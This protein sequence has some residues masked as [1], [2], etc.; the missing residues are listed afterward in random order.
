MMYA[1]V[2]A[3][4][5]CHKRSGGPAAAVQRSCPTPGGGASTTA[6]FIGSAPLTDFLQ[7]RRS[8]LNAPRISPP[9]IRGPPGGTHPRCRQSA[10]DG[11][12]QAMNRPAGSVGAGPVARR[13][14]GKVRSGRPQNMLGGVK[15]GSRLA[16][17]GVHGASPACAGG[18][19]AAARLAVAT[20]SLSGLQLLGG[21]N[22]G[23][24]ATA[25]RFHGASAAPHACAFRTE[26]KAEPAQPQWLM[27]GT[28]LHPP[29]PHQSIRFHYVCGRSPC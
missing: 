12:S 29:P 15:P 23:Q 27:A 13:A 22:R 17:A 19:T 28:G 10:W 2:P 3:A 26:S 4:A 16:A 14:S 24:V 25:R 6:T 8:S 11:S 7:R 1:H 5:E 21:D 9:R 18:G 20:W